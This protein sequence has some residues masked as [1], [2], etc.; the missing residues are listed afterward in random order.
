MLRKDQRVVPLYYQVQHTLTG[1][2]RSGEYP[3]GS[4][5]PSES[6]LSRTLSVSRVTVREALR[7]LTD[8]KLVVKS[9]GKGTFVANP[10]PQLPG[11]RR[12][13]G[14]LEDLYDE[15][16]RVTVRHIEITQ[17]P[18]TDDMRTA[19]ELPA[20]EPTVVRVKRA[21]FVDAAPYAFT[22]NVL[23]LAIGCQLD[24]ATLRRMPVVRILEEVL[25]IAIAGASEVFQAAAADAEIAH[26]LEVPVLSPVMHVRRLL[27]GADRRPLQLVNSYYRSDKFH[28]SV[29]LVRVRDN[30]RGSWSETRKTDGVGQVLKI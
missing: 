4:Q 19:L 5:L 16:P 2:I 27:F 20:S 25:Q 12:F 15:L 6:A 29:Q 7:V 21:R 11:E 14:Y 3:P 13:T 10:L 28:Y 9:Q 1:R 17:V 26:W 18:V 8:E 23:P 30:G 22:V 24:A